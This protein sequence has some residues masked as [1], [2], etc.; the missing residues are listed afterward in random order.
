MA[1]GAGIK[2]YTGSLREM[3]QLLARLAAVKPVTEVE[4]DISLGA[5]VKYL[6]PKHIQLGA[7]LPHAYD[8]AA[9]PGDPA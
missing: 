8:A 1:A 2:V 5:G 3:T 9:E 6:L 4:P 7:D